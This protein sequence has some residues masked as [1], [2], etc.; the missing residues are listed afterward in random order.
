[1]IGHDGVVHTTINTLRAQLAGAVEALNA[2]PSAP[3][4]ET[5]PADRLYPFGEQRIQHYPAIEVSCPGLRY[6]DLDIPNHHA[7]VAAE[8][9][10]LTRCE[11][12]PGGSYGDLAA[13]ASRY[14]I[15]VL[16]VLREHDACGLGSSLANAD[17]RVGRP[18]DI[19]DG[20]AGRDRNSTRYV[21]GLVIAR[22]LWS[23]V[24][25]L[26]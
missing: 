5:I 2:Q 15:A 17:L 1:M 6:G 22:V 13:Q 21:N 12:T 25:S 23:D 20:G 26:A 8:V 7:D 4:L 19:P 11:G 18:T 14:N 9:Y 10:I 24:L 3:T 16:S